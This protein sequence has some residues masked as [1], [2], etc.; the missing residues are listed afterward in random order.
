MKKIIKADNPI[1]E[2]VI[3][4]D[5]EDPKTLD[6]DSFEEEKEDEEFRLEDAVSF[7]NIQNAPIFSDV[8]NRKIKLHRGSDYHSLI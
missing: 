1:I 7:I 8:T 6:I 4:I 2:T 3:D 5:V